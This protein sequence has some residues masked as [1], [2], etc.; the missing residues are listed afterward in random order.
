MNA[1]ILLFSVGVLLLAAEV[2]LPGAIAGILGGLAMLAGCIVAF[3]EFGVAGGAVASVIAVVALGVT[4]YLELVWLPKSRFGRALVVNSAV[5]ATSQAPLADAGEV[6][7][8]TA[9]AVTALVPSG[10]V[11]IDGRRYEAFCRS[12]MVA[13]GEALRV[14]GLDN[15]R[16]I[17]TKV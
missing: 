5:D 3:Q 4:F 8:K 11:S 6:V 7:G 16:L 10:Y 1:V 13:R 9:E 12:G 17:V 15:F 14:V 2:V